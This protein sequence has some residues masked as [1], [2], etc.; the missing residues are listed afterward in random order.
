MCTSISF[1]T[2]DHYFGRN[3]DLEYS[4]NEAVT[5]TPRNFTFSF[6]NTKML[7]THYAIIGIATVEAGYPLYYDAVNEAGLGIAGLNFPGNAVYLPDADGKDNIA[8]FEL[9]PWILAQCKNVSEARKLIQK[10]NLTDI[11]FNDDYPTTPLHWMVADAD[12]SMVIEPTSDGIQIYDNPVGVLTNNPIFPFQMHNLC[13]YLNITRKMPTNRFS[14]KVDLV[15]YSRGMGGIGLPGDL[16]SSSRFVRACFTKLNS[17]SNTDEHSS[18][19]QFF[20]I[21]D[22]VSQTRGCCIVDDTYEITMYS[23]CC[24]TAKGIYYYKTYE[25][26]RITVVF[27][28][29]EDLDSTDLIQ[30]PIRTKCDIF[31]EDQSSNKDC[32]NS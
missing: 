22:S 29:K 15:P 24:N 9:I 32:N 10:I 21:L 11:P 12:E 18:V 31:C 25:N 6:R 19:N 23:S 7:Q 8:P 13:N 30:Y 1:K 20:H 17:V 28:N 27:L 26:P 4:Y 16:S 3:L 14:S 5:I 2:K